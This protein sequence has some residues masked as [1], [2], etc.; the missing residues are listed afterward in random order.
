[1]N[2]LVADVM[3]ESL[4][5]M[6]EEAG[7]QASERPS[8]TREELKQ[9]LYA[10]DGLIMRSKTRVDADLLKNAPRLKIV[11]R[12]GAGIDNLDGS[13]FLEV[14]IRFFLPE[15]LGATDPGPWMDQMNL[16]FTYDQ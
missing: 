14:R 15:T 9:E 8:I 3:H 1:M 2:I 11:A 4:Y 7:F 13:A 16:R 6:L 12:A 5:P 10:F